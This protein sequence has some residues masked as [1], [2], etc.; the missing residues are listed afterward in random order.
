MI[1]PK[2]YRARLIIYSVL[3]ISFLISTMIFTYHH[4]RK[5]VLNEANENLRSAVA[6][7]NT[8]LNKDIRSIENHT[9]LIASNR[10]LQ[11]YLNLANI[12]GDTGPL[13]RLLQQSF[14]WL[15]DDRTVVIS[16]YG[17]LLI[18]A[19]HHLLASEVQKNAPWD[20]QGKSFYLQRNSLE[21]VAVEPIVYRS[22]I[23]GAIALSYSLQHNWQEWHK[24]NN[25]GDIFMTQDNQIVFS[26]SSQLI[27]LPFMPSASFA[28]LGNDVYHAHP[29]SLPHADASLPRLWYGLSE[30]KLLTSLVDQ[31]EQLIVLIVLGTM[32]TLLVGLAIVHSFNSP[33][34]RLMALTEEVIK[35]KLPDVPQTKV[36]TELDVL[37]NNFSTMIEALK[38]KQ[39]QV[40]EAHNE[41]KRS[42]ITDT[43]TGL[44]NRRHLQDI[45][46]KLQAHAKREQR[47]IT[48]SLFD[49]D[50]FKRLNDTYGHLAGDKALVQFSQILKAH[51]RGGDFLYRMGGE[52]FLILSI[53][54]D[55]HGGAV[56]AEKI[57]IATCKRPVKYKDHVID[58][59]VSCGLSHSHG[60][61]AP[62]AS[63]NH[64]LSRA[65][66]ALYAAK[67]GGRNQICTYENMVADEIDP[68]PQ[69]IRKKRHIGLVAPQ[70]TNED[71]ST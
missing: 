48:A 6:M 11:E 55:S 5:L 68:R 53:G 24:Q 59:T 27:G 64:L 12:N 8:Y 67:E 35:G 61:E 30:T 42:S 69:L 9:K 54:K 70:P 28:V 10:R 22:E 3:L 19:E 38:E 32:A 50:Y 18:G 23:I 15:P 60:D 26:T 21:F 44:Y 14:D 65:D 47:T 52:E 40:D 71:I 2:T 37:S 1:L 51:S 4:S 49:L 7:H 39:R 56:L 17:H 31:R 29:V 63:L 43:L 20:G 41:L 46:P 25:G 33:L 58:I 34:S 45:Y 57:R 16:R 13:H 62:E 36:H 66:K